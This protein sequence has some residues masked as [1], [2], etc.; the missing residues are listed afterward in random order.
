MHRHDSSTKV[1]RTKDNSRGVFKVFVI[2]VFFDVLIFSSPNRGR[3]GGGLDL[4]MDL[5]EI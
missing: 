1:R 2:F 3:L 4:S 5:S